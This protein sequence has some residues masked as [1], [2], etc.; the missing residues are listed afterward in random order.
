MRVIL[1]QRVGQ[2]GG[3]GVRLLRLARV[4]HRDQQVVE[5]REILVELVGL[6]PPWQ[7]AGEHPV[8]VGADIEMRHRV[9]GGQRGQQQAAQRHG[10]RMATAEFGQSDNQAVEHRPGRVSGRPGERGR[11]VIVAR[12]RA[13]HA[14]PRRFSARSLRR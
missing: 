9:E 13:V 6:L 2:R 12:A 3:G 11:G 5:L 7:A 10:Q 1:R 8:G 14:A 4:D